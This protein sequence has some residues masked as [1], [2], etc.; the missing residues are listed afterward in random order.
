MTLAAWVRLPSSTQQWQLPYTRQL[1]STLLSRPAVWRVVH[2][3][4][5]STHP[6][7]S[8]PGT[9]LSEQH[10]ALITRQKASAWSNLVY[11]TLVQRVKGINTC[12]ESSAHIHTQ[13][14]AWHPTVIPVLEGTHWC[15]LLSRKTDVPC[16]H[17]TI[18]PH[19]SGGVRSPKTFQSNSAMWTVELNTESLDYLSGIV[20]KGLQRVHL[21]PCAAAARL[22]DPTGLQ[23][24]LSIALQTYRRVSS[25]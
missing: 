22:W 7:S 11:S 12:P 2:I 3:C 19:S 14:T 10:T 6:V 20:W 25:A 17:N 16:P 23:M 21:I 9:G 13:C 1:F 15:A 4:D 8:P 24:Y 18:H 5:R